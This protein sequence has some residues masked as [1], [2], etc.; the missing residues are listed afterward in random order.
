MV[1]NH[2]AKNIDTRFRMLFLDPR[3]SLDRTTP[4]LG[5]INPGAPS[6][7]KE[8]AARI[9]ANQ[10]RRGRFAIRD[11]DPCMRNALMGNTCYVVATV[12]A[13]DWRMTVGFRALLMAVCRR[14]SPSRSLIPDTGS[15]I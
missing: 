8:R 10:R 11:S 9:A 15:P 5:P 13:A 12:T 14:P 6:P 4:A 7:E 2:I 3:S 1:L